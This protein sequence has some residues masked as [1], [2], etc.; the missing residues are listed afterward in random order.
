MTTFST[1]RNP[2]PA[3]CPLCGQPNR[4]AMEVARETGVA[5]PPCWCASVQFE[6]ALLAQIP[7]EAR[8]RACVCHACATQEAAP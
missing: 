5:Q 8:D 4:C 1:D 7:A 3:C 2:D 6:P